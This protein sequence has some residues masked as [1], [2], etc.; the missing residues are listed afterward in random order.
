MKKNLFLIFALLAVTTFV[1]AEVK[2]G[3]INPQMVL[4]NSI[5]GKEAI[6][7]LK[8]VQISE[9][10][11]G[12]TMQNEINALEKDVLSPALN[13]EAR[14]RKTQDLQNKRVELK[15]FAED[16]QKKIMGVQQKEFEKIQGDLMPIIERIAKAEGC[17]LVLDL[18]T[19]GVTYF[20]PAIDITDKVVK[21]YDAQSTA[22]PAPK[23]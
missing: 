22:A 20:D 5:K 4:Q 12:E 19:A 18:N 9:Q 6:E 15:R 17:S 23:K 14:D 16:Y 8:A 13:Q 2:I 11:K 7:R 10:K 1:F 3:I 21:A